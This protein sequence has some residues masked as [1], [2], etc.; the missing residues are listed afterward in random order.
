MM[1]FIDFGLNVY[2]LKLFFNET[3][4]NIGDLC[5]YCKNS[6]VCGTKFPFQCV[7]V[8]TLNIS[9]VFFNTFSLKEKWEKMSFFLLYQKLY[10]YV[11]KNTHIRGRLFS[12]TS[13]IN[14]FRVRACLI[15]NKLNR[16]ILFRYISHVPRIQLG[17]TVSCSKEFPTAGWFVF[18]VFHLLL[19]WQCWLMP[20]PSVF[21]HFHVLCG[22][23]TNK[24]VLNR[25]DVV[26]FIFLKTL[27]LI[28]K[29]EC[30]CMKVSPELWKTPTSV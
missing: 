30:C 9:K 26:H 24:G 19:V 16:N 14:C 2:F 4:M 29:I 13:V 20:V 12:K 17:S 23:F 3:N 28:I 6:K 15:L 5:V 8:Q 7:T 21:C 1:L 10:N 11:W 22:M 18:V 27:L 25:F